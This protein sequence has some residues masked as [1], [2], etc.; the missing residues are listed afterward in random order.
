MRPLPRV[1]VRKPLTFYSARST[2]SAPPSS[3]VYL[4]MLL[5]CSDD[6]DCQPGAVGREMR[7]Y[8]IRL[9]LR[10]RLQLEHAGEPDTLIVEELGL[11]EGE[12]RADLAVINGSIAGYEIK[13]ERDTLDRLPHQRDVYEQCFDAVTLVVGN[14]HLSKS[15]SLI[16]SRWGILVATQVDSKVELRVVRSPKRNRNVR[17]ESVVQLLWKDETLS[18]LRKIGCAEGNRNQ[19]RRTLWAL[20]VSNTSADQLRKIVREALKA[21]GQWQAAKRRVRGNGSLPTA[22]T[23]AD[24]QSNLEWLLSLES[25]DHPG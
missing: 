12:A 22:A 9:A 23:A 13:S 15:R 4:N 24:P 17:P 6:P 11:R 25:P 5:A 14:R 8:D 16:P 19:P 7:D 18:A 1:T 21:R 10:E 3:V 20:L 2:L